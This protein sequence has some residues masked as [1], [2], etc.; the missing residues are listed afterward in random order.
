M[1]AQNGHP[2]TYLIGVDGGGSGCRAAIADIDGRVIGRADGP[3]AN[4]T[5]SLKG[6]IAALKAVLDD[7]RQQAQLDESALASSIGHLGLAGVISP[8][9]ARN[10]AEA[11]PLKRCQVTDDRPT[12]VAGAIGDGDG[13]LAVIGTG[14]FIGRQAGG[15]R[16]FVGGWGYLL[17]DDASGAW[18]GK[19]LLAATLLA[20]DGLAKPSPLTESVLKEFGEASEIVRFAR[21][22][23][24]IEIGGFAPRI[25]DAAENGDVIA[26]ALMC[27]GAEYIKHALAAV[28]HKP[29]ESLC[30]MGSLGPLYAS[31]L[32]QALADCVSTPAGTAIDGALSLAAEL[33]G[34]MR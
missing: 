17:G 16:K 19:R 13:A 20:K 12:N 24:P 5:T 3:A 11:L 25:A 30:L 6:A 31:Y 22:A 23:A 7:V 14:S 32:P 4:P 27:E 2:T 33:A 29:G 9:V 1:A 28:G 26:A 10:V 15:A 8:A 21:D 18:L 34:T